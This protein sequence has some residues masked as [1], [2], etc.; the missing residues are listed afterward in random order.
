VISKTSTEEEEKTVSVWTF[1]GWLIGFDPTDPI[2]VVAYSLPGVKAIEIVGSEETVATTGEEGEK[3]VE[4]QPTITAGAV[5]PS[6][7][8]SGQGPQVLIYHTHTEEAYKKQEDQDYVEL[9]NTRT[10]DQKY[11]VVRVGEELAQ[12]LTLRYGVPVIH[13]TTDH[14]PPELGTAYVRSCKTVESYL[15]KYDELK[16]L[17]DIHRDAYNSRSWEPL[18]VTIDGQE[19]SRIMI[20]IGTGEGSTGAGYKEKPDW[21]KNYLVAQRLADELNQIH[22]GLALPVNV[23]TGRY[24]QHLSTG[25]VLIEMGTDE[26]TL[27]Q[28][29]RSARYLARALAAIM[30][31]S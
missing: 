17:I 3:D 31:G 24:N 2:S 23:K 30:S 18:T 15:E 22:P 1:F 6:I 20:I 5:I 28:A 11:S 7:E 25:A 16:I 9:A 27:D 21:E 8:I 29:V 4:P 26:N 12:Q 14:E 10:T 13:D 19:V